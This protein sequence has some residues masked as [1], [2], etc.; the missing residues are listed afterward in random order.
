MPH[1]APEG[2]GQLVINRHMGHAG[3]GLIVIFK[4][5]LGTRLIGRKLLEVP[6]AQVRDPLDHAV[7]HP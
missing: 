2:H 3:V 6:L 1:R 5:A 7:A 4:Q